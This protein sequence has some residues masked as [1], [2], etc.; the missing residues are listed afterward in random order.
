[1]AEKVR[2]VCQHFRSWVK[3]VVEYIDV[4]IT[5][6]GPLPTNTNTAHAHLK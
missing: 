4:G 3:R 6:A 1:M 5:T 2:Q